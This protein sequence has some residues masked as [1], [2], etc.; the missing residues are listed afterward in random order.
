MASIIEVLDSLENFDELLKAIND[1]GLVAM[2][3]YEQ[4]FTLFA[5][6][7]KAFEN[8]ESAAKDKIFSE[9]HLIMELILH[10]VVEWPLTS[11]ELENAKKL[12]TLGNDEIKIKVKRKGIKVDDASVIQ[13]DLLAENG[14]IHTLDA[15]LIPPDIKKLF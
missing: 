9:P 7:D 2:L 6:N 1:G 15:V 12:R 8:M 3:G 5:P 10:H 14:V 4:E 13:V 11:K